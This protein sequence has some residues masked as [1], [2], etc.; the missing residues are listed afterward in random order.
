MSTQT[1]ITKQHVQP[2]SADPAYPLT[3]T[4]SY[5]IVDGGLVTGSATAV[6]PCTVAQATD[7]DELKTRL[8]AY[9]TANSLPEIDYDI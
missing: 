6:V 4:V 8:D 9:W 3:V 2:S 1:K 5:D 7:V